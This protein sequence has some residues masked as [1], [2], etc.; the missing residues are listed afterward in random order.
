M[1]NIRIAVL[2]ANDEL[3]TFMDNEAPEALHYYEDEL[4]E[5]LQGTANTYTFAVDA[6]H[7]ESQYLSLIHI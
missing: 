4:H 6:K 1:E 3:H 7:P 5:Y 2:S